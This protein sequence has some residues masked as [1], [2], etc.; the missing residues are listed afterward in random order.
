[1]CNVTNATKLLVS[2]FEFLYSSAKEKGEEG[3]ERQRDTADY[4]A[5]STILAVPRPVPI[6]ISPHDMRASRVNVYNTSVG[7]VSVDIKVV[8]PSSGCGC[9][10]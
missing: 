8:D 2:E 9:N 3:K 1:M 10:G 5:K 7:T 4:T 6:W